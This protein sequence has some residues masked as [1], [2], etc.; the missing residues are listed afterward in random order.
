MP[1]PSNPY[2][3]E[4]IWQW[5]FAA[6]SD[7]NPSVHKSPWPSLAEIESI[8]APQQEALWT[9]TLAVVEQVRKAKADASLSMAA[10]VKS[11]NITCTP[12]AKKCI[13]TAADDI[14]RMLRIEALTITEADGDM[15]V[16]ITFE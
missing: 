6:D 13:E 2:I 1:V 4:E 14:T 16:N 8:P 9:V 5:A 7:M 11:V 10:P 15:Q 12:D 3:T